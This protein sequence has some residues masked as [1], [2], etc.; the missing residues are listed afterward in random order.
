LEFAEMARR[1]W[2]LHCLFFAFDGG[3]EEDGASIFQ[4][5]TGARFAEVYMESVN[6]GRTDSDAF[7]TAAEDRAVGFT[8]VPGF[9]V[10]R[11]VIQC[12]VYLSRPGRRS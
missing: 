4:V 6:D 7:S 2:L 3:D 11:T 9:R 5:R 8:V 12:R 1:V 10:G